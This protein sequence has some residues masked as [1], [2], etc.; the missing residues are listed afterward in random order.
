MA[1]TAPLYSLQLNRRMP[2]VPILLFL[3]A[4]LAFA[5]PGSANEPVKLYMPDAPPLTLQNYTGGHGMVGDVT[6]AALA[7]S[8]HPVQIVTEP[9]ARAQMT[10]ASG[11]NLLII[12]LS[13]TPDREDNYTWIS[14][15]MPLERAFFSMDEPVSSFDEARQ[16]YSR[17]GVGLGTAQ[18]EILRREGFRE[19][20]ITQLKLGENPAHLLAL[21]RIDAWFTGIPEAIYIWGKSVHREQKL[22]RSPPLARTD[23]YLACSKDCDPQLVE[24]LR[25]AVET[26]DQ[27]GTSLRLQHTYMPQSPAR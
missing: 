16:H 15:I 1:M 27:D 13:R 17:I 5:S 10:V 12:P 7:R 8:G 4:M 14:P 26:L 24:E 9:W 18:L 25:K 19:N 3:L 21:G 22:H 2:A 6:L 11:H 20:Q 23:L